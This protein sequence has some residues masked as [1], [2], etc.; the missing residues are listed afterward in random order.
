MLAPSQGEERHELETTCGATLARR[1]RVGS[2]HWTISA[3]GWFEKRRNTSIFRHY[4]AS[5]TCF[6]RMLLPLGQF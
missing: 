4:C 6:L 2:P 3:T 1:A 5:S